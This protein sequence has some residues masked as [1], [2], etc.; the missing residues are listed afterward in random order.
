MY[1]E[2]KMYDSVYKHLNNFI[3]KGET[4]CGYVIMP[5]HIHL[6]IYH[7]EE[8]GQ[9]KNLVG[10]L[11]RFMAYDMVELYT[12]SGRTESLMQM[13]KGITD[14]DKKKKQLHRV[15]EDSF[16][17]K[18]CYNDNF[19]Q[20]KLNYIHNNPL[21]PRWNLATRAA[22]YKHS[23]ARFYEKEVVMDYVIPLVHWQKKRW[24]EQDK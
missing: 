9:L 2:L 17:V 1:E 16:D 24:D 7:K 11:K 19:I 12:Q 6:L 13:T 21:N 4:I 10:N 8:N 3:N 20:Q 14:R 22:D 15:F 5:N 18:R 23:S